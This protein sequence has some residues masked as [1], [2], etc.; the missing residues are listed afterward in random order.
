L[1]SVE[2]LLEI[3]NQVVLAEA[4]GSPVSRLLTA[5]EANCAAVSLEH[6]L[7]GGNPGGSALILSESQ[8]VAACNAARSR[9]CT[10]SELLPGFT[11]VLVYPF[12]GSAEGLRALEGVVGS[13]LSAGAMSSNGQSDYVVHG[14]REM[15]GPFSGLRVSGVRS[16]DDL[17]LRVQDATCLVDPIVTGSNGTLLT[18][19]ELPGFELFVASS[20]A[21]FDTTAE[22]QRNLDVRDSFSGL[23]PLLFF[24]RHRRIGL[25]RSPLRWAN[26]IIDDPNLTPRYGFLDFK[27]LAR[28]ILE[29]RAAASIAFIPWNYRRTAHEIVSLFRETWPQLSICIHGCDHTGSEFSTR[30]MWD[31]LPLVDLA[32]RRMQ[33]LQADTSL[34]FERVMVFPQGRFSSEAMRALRASEMLAAVNT[35]LIDC[36]TGRGVSGQELLQPAITSLGGFPLFMRRPAEEDL[37]N[38]ALDLILGKPCLIVT[39][40]QYFEHGVKPLQ[41]ALASLNALD[42]NMV[43]TNL[44]NGISSTYSVNRTPDKTTVRLYSARTRLQPRTGDALVFTKVETDPESVEIL[45]NERPV[46]ASRVKGGLQFSVDGTDREGLT[47]EARATVPGMRPEPAQSPTYRLKVRARRHLTEMRDN[48]LSRFPRL[49]ASATSVQKLWHRPQ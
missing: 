10:F 6:I 4:E 35:E 21:V 29:N 26:W 30:T 18:R 36:Q 3:M 19:F 25:P 12:P 2:S 14:S 1:S 46:A 28:C 49:S 34:G 24:M 8:L 17:A 20:T 32:T 38:F 33:R 44:E 11:G 39:H 23:L 7:A 48:Y 42:P 41:S 47:V 22:Y 45:V 27:T 37:A 15:C 31:A 13:R 5:L 16:R 9:S 43:W 40:H